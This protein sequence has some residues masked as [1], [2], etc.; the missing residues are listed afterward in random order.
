MSVFSTSRPNPE[1]KMN[2][3]LETARVRK[4]NIKAL[5]EEMDTKKSVEE[6]EKSIDKAGEGVDDKYADERKKRQQKV[7]TEAVNRKL[8]LLEKRLYKEGCEEL[9]NMAI[10]EM[11]YN[12]FWLEDSMKEA[13]T[14][15]LYTT[16]TETLETL[17][18]LGIEKV[19]V[20]N[21][22]KFMKNLKDKVKDTADKASKRITKAAKETYHCKPE[23]VD[24]IDF[25]L[26]DA[27]DEELTNDLSELG[28]EE[29]EDLVK[30]K[31]LKVVNDE[32]QANKELKAM[33]DDI[34]RS[35]KDAEAEMADDDT[36]DVEGEE[37]VPAKES[38]ELRVARA[39]R[40]KFNKNH[41]STLFESIMMHTLNNM[42]NAI[43]TEGIDASQNDKMSATFSTALYTYT[44]LETLNTLGMYKFDRIATKKLTDHFKKVK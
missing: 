14:E 9:F 37:E 8:G 31:V 43:V 10:F 39:R 16:F 6:M 34:D 3:L 1:A 21:E 20:L 32:Q 42:N 12:A 41:A 40:A 26:S 22:S 36:E 38:F 35:V 5:K 19:S 25:S 2:A 7:T 44:I 18:K 33:L 24:S 27:E 28:K 13:A 30:Q 17:D 23:E 11:T 4:R 15:S 29:I